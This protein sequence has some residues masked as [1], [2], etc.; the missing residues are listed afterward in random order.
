MPGNIPSLA[1]RIDS[2]SERDVPLILRFIT[3]LAEYEKL[4]HQVVATEAMLRETLF[5]AD[6][7]A[8]VVIARVGEEPAGFALWF[9]NYST[10]LARPGLYLED[11][12]VLPEWRGHGVGRFL[13]THL[14][15]LAVA[16][17]CGRM[18]WS[19]LEWN[20]PAVGFYKK[21]GAEVMEEWR[22]CRLTGETLTA[23]GKER[24]RE[25]PATG[26]RSPAD[27]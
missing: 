9:Y 1:L 21:L 4:E 27:E 2:T 3:A 12:F 11:L 16:R 25:K 17:G 14:A 7:A 15:A 8:H 19:V 13:L 10:F 18:E 6:P 23:L 24:E 22:I 26:S 20:A 5:G